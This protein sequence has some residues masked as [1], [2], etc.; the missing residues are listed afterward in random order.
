MLAIAE[1]A[2]ILS[3]RLSDTYECPGCGE[4]VSQS[5]RSCGNC[6]FDL[7]TYTIEHGVLDI[8]HASAHDYYIR[9]ENDERYLFIEKN[10]PLPFEKSEVFRL[11][12]PEQ[13]LIHMKF[14]NMVNEKEESIGDLWL[15]LDTAEQSDKKDKNDTFHVEIA[16]K[17]DENNLIEVSAAMKEQP[18]IKLSKKLSRGKADEKLYLSLEQTINEANR[19]KYTYY[20]MIDLLHRAL[21]VIKDINRIV[22]PETDEV[23]EIIYKKAKL[24]L[25]KAR[26]MSEN[27]HSGRTVINYANNVL[28]SFGTAIPPGIQKEI[29]K[30]IKRLEDMDEKGTYE[31]NNKAI[32]DLNNILSEKLDAVNQLMEIQ[33]AGEFCMRTKPSKAPRFFKYIKDILEALAKKDEQKAHSL[34]DEIMPD[35]YSVVDKEEAKPGVIYKDIAR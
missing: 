7:E 2:A 25:D 12:H 18:Q 29:R 13:R 1:G 3:H 17:I 14:Y 23:D 19:N 5:D 33:K 11:V 9:L 34:L 6:E 35:V 32:K 30:K 15:G 10:T 21:S 26:K 16:L 8:V 24:K 27:G 28:W 4:D 20:V 31:E 22:A